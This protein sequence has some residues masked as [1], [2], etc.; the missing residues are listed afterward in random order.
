VRIQY[1]L[2]QFWRTLTVKRDHLELDQALVFLSPE[3]QTLFLQM[4]LS[5]QNHA[6]IVF[7]R[8]LEQGE[9][10]PDLLVAALLH[11]V[12]KQ[13]YRMSPLERAIIVLVKAVNPQQACRWGELP[14]TGWDSLPSWRKAFVVALHHAEWGAEMARKSGVSPLAEY[15][16]RLHDHPNRHSEDKEETSLL[17]KLWLVDNES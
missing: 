9:N 12:G 7:Q 13:R 4:Q 1:R 5:E 3:Q 2:R 11:D 14:H 15:L 8:L 10:Q 6:V 16:I 17:H